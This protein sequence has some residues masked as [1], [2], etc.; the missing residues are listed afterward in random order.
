M[1]KR[2]KRKFKRTLKEKQGYSRFVFLL[3]LFLP[4]VAFL[5]FGTIIIYPNLKESVEEIS[6]DIPEVDIKNPKSL[7]IKNA[8][9]LGTTKNNEPYSILIKNTVEIAENRGEIKLDNITAAIELKGQKWLSFSANRV[10]YNSKEKELM[11]KGNI[12]LYDSRGY[13]FETEELAV[14][15]DDEMYQSDSPVSVISDDIVIKSDRIVGLSD[16]YLKFE[17]K[18]KMIIKKTK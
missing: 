11:L 10:F 13:I 5:I 3:K 8:E 12:T 4:S 14:F 7:E 16:Y 18:P 6:F 9:F 2:L 15:L 1:I 17:G